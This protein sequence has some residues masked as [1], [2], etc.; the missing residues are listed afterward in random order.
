VYSLVSATPEQLLHPPR[1]CSEFH[2][3]CSA[4]RAFAWLAGLLGGGWGFLLE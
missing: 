4:D 3:F 1:F 2:A